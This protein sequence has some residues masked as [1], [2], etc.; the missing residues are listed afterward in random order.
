MQLTRMLI[1]YGLGQRLNG[2]VPQRAMVCP[3]ILSVSGKR[4]FHVAAR[5]YKRPKTA[6][7]VRSMEKT[8]AKQLVGLEQLKETR[9]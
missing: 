8:S 4:L 9:A 2:R 6:A 7:R 3:S 5:A 1:E